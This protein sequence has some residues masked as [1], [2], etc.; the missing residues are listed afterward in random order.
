VQY[1]RLLYNNKYVDLGAR[2]VFEPAPAAAMETVDVFYASAGHL[3]NDLGT[4]IYLNSSGTREAT[5]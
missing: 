1:D 5:S 4:K 3:L 2:Y